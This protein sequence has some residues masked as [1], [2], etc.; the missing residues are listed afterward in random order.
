MMKMRRTRTINRNQRGFTL[1]ELL[2]AIAISAVIGSAVAGATY[3]VVN[4][5]AVSTNHQIVINQVQNA[6]NSVSRDAE[7]AQYIVP[8][9]SSD[10][11]LPLGTEFK[12]VENADK[13]TLIW[14]DW[15]NTYTEVTYSV[16]NGILQRSL[17][18]NGV[19]TSLTNV[20]NNISIASGNWNS[21]TKVL[22]V[23]IESRITI[24]KT[25]AETRIFQ[26]MPRSAK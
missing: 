26:I 1:A 13:L 5:N 14:T 9:N 17:K 16:V 11:A 3:Q 10:I 23:T 6:V 18:V 19:Q 2:I 24:P 8:K 25:A 7:Q 12:L 15:D 20:A 21:S 4:I 22:N